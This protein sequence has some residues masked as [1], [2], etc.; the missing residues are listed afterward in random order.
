MKLAKIKIKMI[1]FQSTI[2]GV[3]FHHRDFP[4]PDLGLSAPS[5]F[6]IKGSIMLQLYT[7]NFWYPWFSINLKWQ[8]RNLKLHQVSQLWWSKCFFF[9]SST[10]PWPRRQNWKILA[11]IIWFV[12]R[13]KMSVNP[14]EPSWS[15]STL[16]IKDF[17]K[18]YAQSF[19][20]SVLMLYVPV[21]NFSV[22]SGHFLV[23]PVLSRGKSV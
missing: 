10:G 12:M 20:L 19:C 9:T 17:C 2:Q 18:S 23:D 4:R 5:Q 1:N 7:S 14:D 16:Q 6:P 21:N 15:G 13:I 3:Q 8:S 22:M 11:S